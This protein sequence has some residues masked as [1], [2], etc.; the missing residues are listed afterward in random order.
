MDER[1]FIS[2][3]HRDEEFV[4]RLAR[5]LEERG[6]SV[7]IDRG[8]IHAGADWRATIEQA[9]QNSPVFLL[10]ISPDALK[11]K[12]VSREYAQAKSQ[13]KPI[14]PLLYRKTKI[15]QNLQT[16]L[17]GYQFIDFMEGNYRDKFTDLITGLVN[18]GV[19][20]GAAPEL[21][22]EEQ[23]QRRLERLGV[24]NKVRWGSVLTRVPGWAFAWG[25][26]WTIYW[27]VM[28]IFLVFMLNS[29]DDSG[30]LIVL[31]IGGF[32]GGGIGGLWAGLVTMF[33]LRH[34]A[35]SIMWK[36]MR[37]SIRIWG[38]VGPIGSTLA[39]GVAY[40]LIEA[41]L[42][43]ADCSGLSIGDCFGAA[44][45]QGLAN[46]FS[47]IVGTV[48]YGFLALLVLGC[49]AGWLAVRHIRRLEPGILGR[50]AIW[51]IL[52][53]GSGAVIAF[54]GTFVVLAPFLE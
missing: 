41:S 42:T 23:A 17:F 6:V 16:E 38:L 48:F 52:G 43:S 35:G 22:P 44:I 53:W 15:P 9:I 40:V 7:W 11:S 39:G 14:F 36:H 13:R 30:G 4:L 19:Q 3:S 25:L 12:Y 34:H 20:V 29:S 18:A 10:V 28:L 51:V 8:D 45:G 26:G 1:I 33:V 21:S 49:I 5:Q 47:L 32:F 37:S 31:P 27:I 46:A 24:P 50:Q 2:Y 54:I